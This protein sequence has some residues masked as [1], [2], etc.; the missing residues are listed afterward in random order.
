MNKLPSPEILPFGKEALAHN[1][2]AERMA[3]TNIITPTGAPAETSKLLGNVAPG[4]M[5]TIVSTGVLAF[6]LIAMKTVVTGKAP[7]KKLENII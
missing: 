1:A 3:F 6:M 4:I 2:A 5:N 7:F